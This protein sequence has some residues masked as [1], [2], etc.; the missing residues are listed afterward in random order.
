MFNMFFQKDF[1]NPLIS[2]FPLA[3]RE[4][5]A[6]HVLDV[7]GGSFLQWRRKYIDN[8]GNFLEKRNKVYC[9]G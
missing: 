2:F 6:I 5:Q 9:I 7:M 1:V 3:L 8:G 4:G